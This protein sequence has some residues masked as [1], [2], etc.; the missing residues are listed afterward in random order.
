MRVVL[1]AERNSALCKA[2]TCYGWVGTN[3]EVG[4]DASLDNPEQMADLEFINATL[5]QI[6][7][8]IVDA[9]LGGRF[10]T[11][12]LPSE[13]ITTFVAV[14]YAFR[15]MDGETDGKADI[16]VL[17]ELIESYTGPGAAIEP[18]EEDGIVYDNYFLFRLPFTT[19][20]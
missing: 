10:S 9:G 4:Y 5:E 3:W 7:N 11:W 14:D 18:L 19:F 1:L 15:W 8:I 13:I 17:L 12:P 20:R 2:K 16:N 6:N